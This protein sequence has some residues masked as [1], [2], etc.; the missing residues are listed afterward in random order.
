LDLGG[1]QGLYEA[2]SNFDGAIAA[3]K[4]KMKIMQWEGLHRTS[5]FEALAR[6]YEANIDFHGASSAYSELISM[7]PDVD[8]YYFPRGM[9]YMLSGKAENAISDFNRVFDKIQQLPADQK[10]AE[11]QAQIT[12][13]VWLDIATQR[14]GKPTRLAALL[15]DFDMK[16]WPGPIVQMLLGK[17]TPASLVASSDRNTA[18]S[19]NFFAGERA[20][21]MGAKD[22]AIQMFRTAAA[23][24]NQPYKN[25]STAELK[26]LGVT[27]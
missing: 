11:L 18:C 12:I 27:P 25:Y 16:P 7:N 2:K 13:A 1:L 23:T 19:N 4:E 15:P 21:L 22:E 9:A 14:A 10:K 17:V 26:A 3:L 24:C 5:Y 8:R 6:L 20:M